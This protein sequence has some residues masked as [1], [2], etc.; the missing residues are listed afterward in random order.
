MTDTANAPTEPVF[1]SNFHKLAFDEIKALIVKRNDLVGRANAATG[2]RLTLTEQIRENSTDPAIVEAREK[3]SEA[4][5]ALEALVKP[6]VDQIIANES[7]A[8][9]EIE[10]A[11]KAVDAELKPGLTYLKKSAGDDIAKFLPTQERVKGV[12]IGSSGGK[13][14]RGYDVEITVDGET[15]KFTNMSTAAQFLNL[16]TSD[17]QNAFFGKASEMVGKPVDNS[18][19]A[20]DVVTFTG[21]FESTDEKGEVT[22]NEAFVKVY[23]TE[24]KKDE[25]P[26]ESAP[27][28]TEATAP[29]AEDMNLED[30]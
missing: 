27:E 19:D 28:A 17:L 2:D 29:V 5:M 10:A 20:P 21:N 4:I 9:D 18:K 13:R 7:G 22:T 15:K 30:F 14:I 16:D 6:V 11:I 23:R 3:M 1:E 12:R 8:I 24:V 26:A 25:V